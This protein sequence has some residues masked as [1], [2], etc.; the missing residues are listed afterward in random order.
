MN[1]TTMTGSPPG[2]PRPATAPNRYGH[3][4]ED[5]S[6][7]VVTD[8]RTP[9]P[10][11]NVIATPR[12]GLVVSQTGSGFTW[13]DN[14]QLG[15][16]TRWQ[17]DL[18]HDSSGKFLYV[19]DA[20]TG[21]VW[22]LSPA[23]VWPRY[24]RF[25]CRH[26]LGATSFETEL[27]GI[28]ARWSLFCHADETVEL[29]HV[30]LANLGDR[31]RRLQLVAYLEWNCGVAPSPRREFTRLFL[32]T[33]F[34]PARRAVFATSHMWEVP[35]KRFGHW[36][37]EFPYV[38]ALACSEPVAAAQ[39]DKLGFTGRY[40]D[41]RDPAALTGASWTP[42]FGRHG[43]AVAA[44]CSHLT[45]A[46]H[47]RR[48]VGYA[49]AVAASRAEVEALVERTTDPGAI[50]RALA[51][52]RAGWRARLAEH[53]V[54]TPDPTLDLLANDW[55]RYQAISSRLWGRC[56]YY[57]QSGAYGFR[58]QLQDSQVWLT[59][60]PERCRAQ[61]GL[62]AAHQF[63][64]GSVYHWWHPL[65]EQGH[66]TRM[67]DD[68]LW[69]AFVTASYLRETGRFE[70]LDDPAPFLDDPHTKP[71]FDHVVR[72]FQR[73]F[74]RTSPRGLPYI[75]AGDWNDG[76]SAVGLEERG[77]SVW[78][79]HF[80]AGLL[81]EWTVICERAGRDGVAGTFA[82]RRRRLVAAINEHG[83]D[84]E[85]YLRGTLDDGTPLGSASNARGKIFLNAQTWAILADVA[86]PERAA[87]CMAAVKEHLVTDA[88]S[89]LLAPAFDE[90][91]PEIGYITR[92]APGLRENGGV[93]TH[94]A[95]WAIAAAC[96]VRDH[97]LVGRLLAAINPS[98]KDPERYWAEP[99]VLPG[100]VDGPASPHHG[101]AGWTWYTGSAAWL[102]RVVCEWVL[103]VRPEWGGL[104]LDPCLPPGW[105]SAEMTRP[106]RGATYHIAI[107]RDAS[108]PEGAPARVWLDCVA[109]PGNV[110]A[111]PAAPGERH[112][113]RVRCR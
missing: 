49:L 33:G 67:T 66:V 102:H 105:T 61:I 57:Q 60:E 98:L 108:I 110:V 6:E 11:V 38:S 36:N 81:A 16:I 104:R 21:A 103:G 10:W 101:R 5:G 39:G 113:V 70:I 50:E 59:I 20:E 37:A 64:D 46:P 95:T 9:R 1:A 94:A 22:S 85:W 2:S 53:R 96:K 19:R 80:L 51:E 58:D 63:A 71:L 62:H 35:S 45:L 83:W 76:L 3:F 12:L 41:L 74:S 55:L 78:L 52:V 68:L 44:L 34:D 17:Q 87:R 109:Q 31:P 75:G 48:A 111:A 92:Y 13:I 24:D 107:E 84:G 7:Y 28:A 91:I 54:R 56:G 29:W 106:Y 43:D 82:E 4:S 42:E 88:G 79:G 77:E 73:T 72:A 90:P 23:P 40:R 65:S 30:E 112:E 99:Y 32:E 69:L 86:S 18:A 97:E 27:G 15:V 93:Y 8:P 25:E 100:N 89:L 26:G 47:G 14:S